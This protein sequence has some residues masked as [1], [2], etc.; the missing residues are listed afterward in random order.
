MTRSSDDAVTPAVDA[1]V[2]RTR[3]DVLRTAL[4]VLTGEGWESVTHARVAE[5]AGYSRATVYKHWPRRTDLLRDAFTRLGDMPHHVPTGDLRAD[6]IAEVTTFRTGMEQH[7]LDRALCVLVDRSA[8]DP[9]LVA[10]RDKLV[11]DGEQ[12]VRQLLAP[13]LDGAA[14]DAA[15]LMPYCTRR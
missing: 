6:L 10:V 13:L 3:N 5:V 14:L 11:T 2:V 15:T 4:Q 7:R 8:V 1:R 9:E 12:V